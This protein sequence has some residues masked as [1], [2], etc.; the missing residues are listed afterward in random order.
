MDGEDTIM[1]HAFGARARLAFALVHRVYGSHQQ[2][3]ERPSWYSRAV[4]LSS[5]LLFGLAAWL[6]GL[7]AAP[8]RV[9]P[10]LPH[11]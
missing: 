9:Y 6:R 2:P 11:P 8:D 10:V 7:A 3:V 1:S 5:V 4:V